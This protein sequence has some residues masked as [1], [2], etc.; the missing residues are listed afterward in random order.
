MKNLIIIS[1]IVIGT[2]LSHIRAQSTPHSDYLGVGHIT[3]VEVTTSGTEFFGE[4]ENTINGSGMDQHYSDAARFLGQSTTGA[5]FETIEALSTESF[6]TWIDA[7]MLLPEMNYLDTTKAIWEHFVEAYYDEW[8][9][10]IIFGNDDVFPASFYWRMAWWNNSMHGEDLLRQKITLALSELFVVSEDSRLDS[11]AFGLASYYDMLNHGAFGNYRDL[12]ENVTYHAAMGYYLSYIDNEPTNEALNIHPD[13][14]YAREIMQLFTIGLYELNQDGSLILDDEEM[15][16]ETY[17]NNDIGEFARI[18]TGLTP[19]GYWAPWEDLSEEEVQ[20]GV[21]YN[22]IPFIDATL[23]LVMNEDYHEVGEKHLLNGASTVVGASGTQDIAS[24]LDNLFYHSNTA[25]FISKHLIMRLVK[26]NPS[27]EYI[28]R[29][30]DVFNSNENGVR[31]D[32]GSVVKAI[33]LDEEARDCEWLGHPSSGKMRE[34]MIRY[35]QL[36]KAFDASNETGKMWSVGWIPTEMGQHPMSSPSVFNFFLPSY[37]PSGPVS[38][39]ELVAPEFELLNSAIAVEYINMI[40]DMLFG[41]YYMESITLAS[42]DDIGYPWWDMGIDYEPDHV[43][44]DFGDEI[45][46]AAQDPALLIER[47]D[48]LLVGGTL[49]SETKSIILSVI[50]YEELEPSDKIKI[51][52]FYILISPDYIIQK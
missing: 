52:L 16:I 20:W 18:F 27:P 33:L 8:G 37:A 21:W 46:A 36:L 40:T 44:L 4:G 34:P 2:C 31:G 11:D 24:A 17:D 25:P 13:E 6:D 39:E 49:S 29:I 48:L 14:N 19:A 47:L 5:N 26:S 1:L 41:E 28:G 51:A 32:L 30:A 3:G 43:N 22:T 23:P 9:E 12:L 45:L 42:P 15:P 7:Q 10:I 50:D 35:N 38:D